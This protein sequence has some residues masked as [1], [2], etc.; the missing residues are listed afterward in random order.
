MTGD[1]RFKVE[2]WEVSLQMPGEGGHA[3]ASTLSLPME[4]QDGALSTSCSTKLKKGEGKKTF[5]QF[6]SRNRLKISSLHPLS[7]V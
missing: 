6:G 4:P 2:W 1:N 7:D 3:N 5:Y